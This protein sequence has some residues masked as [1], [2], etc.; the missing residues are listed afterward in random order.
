MTQVSLRERKVGALLGAFIGDALALG[1]HW[2]YDL[3][4]QHHYYGRWI[5][6]YMPPQEGRYH[7]GLL[8]GA[9]SQAGVILDLTA[10]S[11]VD[12]QGYNEADFCRRLDNDLFPLLDGTP[13]SGPGGYTSQSIRWAW[14][15]RHQGAPWG[16]VAGGADTTEAAER[17]LA[18]A[19]RYGG[20]AAALAQH[21]SA[22]VALTQH[23]PTV[24]AMT[25]AYCVVLGQLVNG[26]ALDATLSGK[27]MEMVSQGV[28]PF[29]HVTNAAKTVDRGA[30]KPLLAGQFP[31]PDALLT[32]S[33]IA[34]AAAQH[35]IEPAWKASLVYGMPCAVYHQ[36]PAAYYLAARFQGD[37][38]S[39]LLHAVNGGGQNQARAILAGA[40]SGAVGGV[41]AI[42]KRF[43]NG[44]EKGE[45]YLALA[46]SLADQD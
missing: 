18:I 45:E 25:L 36:F 12:N 37:V 27:L 16:E 24:A 29:H 14:T 20:D 7:A 38:E 10:Q 43:I 6:D 31:S 4:Q 33:N 13:V 23:D 41:G 5:N 46:E 35:L 9:S 32:V 26:E 19:V 42:P 39:T 11:L 28:L 15:R 34:E 1:P 44:L 30:A 21:V 3:D 2:F 22:N 17:C 8:A 40:L